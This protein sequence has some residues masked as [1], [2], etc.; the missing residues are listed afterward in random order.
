MSA[1]NQSEFP[2]E[3]NF[4][5][6]IH[7]EVFINLLPN[8]ADKVINICG[9]RI[10]FINNKFTLCSISILFY[11]V[12][13]LYWRVFIIGFF[14]LHCFSIAAHRLSLVAASGS[15]LFAVVWRLLIAVASLVA[16]HKLYGTGL[17]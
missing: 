12:F 10:S 1:E 3:D 16:E 4:R 17:Q 2:K 6:K 9:S 15:L 14:W 7:T 11:I 5:L 13:T 8:M